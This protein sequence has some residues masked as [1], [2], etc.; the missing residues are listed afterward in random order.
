MLRAITGN[1]DVPG[2]DILGMNIIRS[3]PTLK[4]KLPEGMG[5]KRLGADEFKLLGGWRAFMP[6]AHIPALFTAM[7]TGDPYRVRALLIFGNNPHLRG[8]SGRSTKT[9][10]L[11]IC[12][13]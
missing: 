11:S 2:G 10:W 12:S 4:D 7:R 1:I 3:Y 13:R 9:S 8:D 5:K 6:S